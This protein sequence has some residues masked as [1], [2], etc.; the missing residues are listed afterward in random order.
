[1]RVAFCFDLDSTITKK[2][3][4]PTLSREIGLEYEMD[5]LTELTMNG[6]VPFESSFRLRA[7]L[8]SL[9]PLDDCI[10]I[11][12]GIP[13]ELKIVEFV[14]RNISDCYIVTGNLDV[15][16]HSLITN[17]LGCEYFSSVA[18][19]QGGKLCG[20]KTIVN[21]ACVIEQLKMIYDKVIAVGDGSNDI[22]MVENANV[23]IAYSGVR[24][25]PDDLIKAADLS[26]ETE[27]ELCAILSN[28]RQTCVD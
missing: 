13:L 4:I 15:L 14:K 1:M 28:E 11:I 25:A 3:I 23:G 26:A 19:I 20:V 7:K 10:R 8:I 6:I 17:K 22:G 9:I 12:S 18:D 27:I 16:V 2:E 24:R 5:L 21:K